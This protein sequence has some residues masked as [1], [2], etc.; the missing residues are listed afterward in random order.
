MP[1]GAFFAGNPAL[2]GEGTETDGAD[3]Q[4]RL[5]TF[6]AR[7]KAFLLDWFRDTVI[8]VE[9]LEWTEDVDAH[10]LSVIEDT[11]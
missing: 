5:L 1:F 6:E 11:Y 9:Q 3:A 4:L 7:S 10:E 8:E 2:S